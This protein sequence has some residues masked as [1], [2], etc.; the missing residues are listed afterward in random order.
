MLLP[1]A[2]LP[3]GNSLVACWIQKRVIE[4]NPV[5]EIVWELTTQ[6]VPELNLTWITSLQTLHNGNFVIGNFLRGQEGKDAHAFEIIEQRKS[7]GISRTTTWS[8]PPPW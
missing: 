6:D 7:F 4:V 8:K 1:V 5:G 3:N 2:C